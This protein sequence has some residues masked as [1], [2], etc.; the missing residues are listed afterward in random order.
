MQTGSLNVLSHRPQEAAKKAGIPDLL[1]QKSAQKD[2]SKPHPILDTPTSQSETIPSSA[3]GQDG[4]HS[5]PVFKQPVA[6]PKHKGWSNTYTQR[7]QADHKHV[8]IGF[9]E[10]LRSQLFSYTVWPDKASQEQVQGR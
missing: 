7:S 6:P 2:E 4:G 8:P 10:G 1:A 9:K 3:N 5:E